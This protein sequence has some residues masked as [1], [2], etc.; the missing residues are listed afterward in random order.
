MTAG[1]VGLGTL[2]G[3]T[4]LWTADMPYPPI[5]LWFFALAM[6]LACIAGPATDS[7]MGAVPQDKSGVA[8]AMNDGTR[9]VAGAAQHRRDRL[10]HHL[11][12]QLTRQR[13]RDRPPCRRSGL[14]RPDPRDRGWAPAG[15][16]RGRDG[17]GGRRLHRGDGDGFA[18]AGTAAVLAAAIVK[19]RLLAHHRAEE[20]DSR[21]TGWK[22]A[23]QPGLPRP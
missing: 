10:A 17:G 21:H 13:C 4:L 7:V 20:A 23:L 2:L 22:L 18:V 1:L 8:S 5:G 6:S 12:L 9:Q 3:L 11:A 14:D 19:Q 15:P 16:G